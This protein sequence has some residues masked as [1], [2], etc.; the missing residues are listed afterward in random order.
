[1]DNLIEEY[2]N[3]GSEIDEDEEALAALKKSISQK[4]KKWKKLVK[5]VHKEDEKDIV[6]L[7]KNKW[8]PNFDT[9]WTKAAHEYFKSRGL[10]SVN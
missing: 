1:M 9:M 8:Y 6:W 2:T 7:L 4:R 5:E 3:L 10:E